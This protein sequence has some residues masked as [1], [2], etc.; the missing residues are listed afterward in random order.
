MYSFRK[1]KS[2]HDS[3]HSACDLCKGL[4]VPNLVALFK[5]DK[6]RGTLLDTALFGALFVLICDILA[7]SIL[8]PYEIPIELIVGIVGSM[9]FIAMLMY[10]LKHGKKA[11]RPGRHGHHRRR[12]HRHYGHHKE[13][14]SDA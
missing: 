11:I 7:R 12:H 1:W 2:G 6:I 9:I 13:A 10:K 14:A 4:I 8:I 3:F 5:G